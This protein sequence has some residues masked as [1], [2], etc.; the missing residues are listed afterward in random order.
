MFLDSRITTKWWDYANPP[1]ITQIN[2]LTD[3]AYK[4]PSK[5]CVNE[6]RLVVI[7]PS[8]EGQAFKQSL[9]ENHTWCDSQGILGGSAAGPRVYNGQYLA[10]YLFIWLTRWR[11]IDLTKDPLETRRA[12]PLIRQR[13]VN[14]EIGICAGSVMTAAEHMGLDTGFGG[15]HN[16]LTLANLLGYPGESAWLAMGVGRGLDQSSWVKSTG[17]FKKPITVNGQTL[18]TDYANI[19]LATK[20]H[21]IRQRK[22]AKA[23]LVKMR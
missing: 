21:P 22:P 16:Y 15:C 3:V 23:V 17:E 6:W 5:Q 14:L 7:G 9:Y 4:T 8:T 11:E 13:L 12:D 20:R 10:P 19:P 18:G 1:T 2:Q